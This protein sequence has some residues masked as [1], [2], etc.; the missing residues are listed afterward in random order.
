MDIFLGL[1]VL[2]VIITVISGVKI[3]PQSET[4][5]IERL[6]R[7]QSVL[8]PGINIIWPFIDKPRAIY[9]RGSFRGYDGRYVTRVAST[10]R[11]DLREQV[12]DFPSQQVITKEPSAKPTALIYCFTIF[13]RYALLSG[14]LT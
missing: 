11:I 12:Y 1:L 9:I 2:I 4:R 5:V 7:F 10:T 8:S 13:K 14:I 6:G 3:V